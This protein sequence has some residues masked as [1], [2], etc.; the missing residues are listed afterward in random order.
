MNWNIAT[1]SKMVATRFGK[2]AVRV[3]G[4]ADLAPLLLCQRFR[5]TMED[6]DPEFISRLALGRQ[7]IR[8]DS[9]GIGESEGEPPNAIEAMAEIVPA[10]LDALKLDRTD[11]LGWSLGGYVAQIVALNWPQRVH[12]LVIAGSGPGGPD[13]PLPHPRVAEIAVKQVPTQ[14]DLRFLFF[15]DSKAGVAAAQ[16]HLANIRVGE[17]ALVSAESGRRQ[18]DAIVAWWRGERAARSRLAELSLPVLVANGVKD[19]MVPAEHSFAIARTAPNA[20]LV[21][22][23]DAGHAFLFLYAEEFSQEVLAFLNRRT[24]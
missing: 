12:R 7:V 16:H 4:G 23:P 11:L 10:L 9:A 1:R 8:F 2:L 19:V 13:R 22:Y 20:K 3:D 18:R 21:L 17:D 5:G 24:I 6:W 14:E 15:T